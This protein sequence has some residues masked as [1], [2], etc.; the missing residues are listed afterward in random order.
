M[1]TLV[2]PMEAAPSPKEPPRRSM[3]SVDAEVE[4]FARSA[5]KMAAAPAVRAPQVSL[6]LEVAWDVETAV[7]IPGPVGRRARAWTSEDD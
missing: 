6:D 4:W 7:E 5:A 3:A 1:D 2:D